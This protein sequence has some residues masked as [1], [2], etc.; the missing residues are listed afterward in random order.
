[1]TM[2]RL[3]ARSFSRREF[4]ALSAM[5]TGGLVLA[6]CGA[7]SAPIASSSLAPIGPMESNLSIYNWDQYLNPD[8][9]KQFQAM[10]PNLKVDTATYASNEDMLAKIE[11]GAKGYDIVVPTGYMVQIMVAKN[12]LLPLDFRQLGNFSHVDSEFR[13]PGYDSGSKHSVPK[14]WGTTGFGFRTDKLAPMSTWKE[15]FNNADRYKGKVAVLDG[16]TEVVGMALKAHGFS[17]NSDKDSELSQARD[18]LLKFK[19]FVGKITSTDYKA[20]LT[21][22]DIWI[23]MGWNGDFEALKGLSP[24]PPVQYVIPSEGAE[25]WVDCWSILASAPHPVAAHTFINYLLDPKIEAQEIA[26]TYYAQAETDAKNL[27]PDAIKNDPIIFPADQ[28]IRPLETRKAT[29]GG[30]KARDQ[31]FAQFKAA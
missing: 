10:Y 7:S 3:D 15:F 13:N 21:T 25:L 2:D 19:P 24:A 5:T 17:Y 11:A 26:Y 20:D 27:M 23:A 29:P 12:L 9:L 1:M 28:A 22:G 31:I 18:T 4:L 16:A 8:T 6:A 30:Q 14:D